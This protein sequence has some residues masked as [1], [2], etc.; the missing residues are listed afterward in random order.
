MSSLFFSLLSDAMSQ[1]RAIEPL[2]TL[3]RVRVNRLSVRQAMM[4]T[5][6]AQSATLRCVMGSFQS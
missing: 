1:A 2:P 5:Y 6:Q 4:T 3:G